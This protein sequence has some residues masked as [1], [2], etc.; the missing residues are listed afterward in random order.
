MAKLLQPANMADSPDIPLRSLLNREGAVITAVDALIFVSR[1][2]SYREAPASLAALE[3]SIADPGT[4]WTQIVQLANSNGVT[5]ALWL[6]LG[7][8]GLAKQLPGDL[9][10]YLALIHDQNRR[11]NRIIVEQ[12]VE[13]ASALNSRG[14]SPV[15][16]KGC[17]ALLEGEG[18][19]GSS[20]MTDI[21]MLVRQGDIADAF[22][23]L[24]SIGYQT[25]SESP[26]HAHAWTFHRPL[27][28]VTIDLHC[29][30]GPQRG[31]LPASAAARWAVPIAHETACMEGLD[32]K[33]R[34]LLLAMSFG[35]F[36]RY[37]PA[38]QIPLNNLHNLAALCHRHGDAIDW[39]F[40]ADTAASYRFQREAAA[41]GLLAQC[42]LD[43]P[44]P[45]YLSRGGSGRRYLRRCLLQL[46]FPPLERLMRTY[47]TLAWPFNRFR[48]DYRYGSGTEGPVLLAARAGHVANILA[49][50][51]AELFRRNPAKFTQSYQMSDPT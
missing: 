51:G 4:D 50:H 44:V 29:H 21:D 13:A 9:Q 3:A 7:R 6:G 40:I 11:R 31:L 10:E 36:E 48:M 37:Y 8:K 22:H 43:I 1:A 38:G 49:R 14:V 45:P 33:H 26:A 2:L 15:F 19:I 28:L 17:L 5:P 42:L 25:L 47:A 46:A 24:R 16:M 30:V 39:R 20:M 23:A 18:D 34:V 27:S 32:L 35:I 41:W 12:A